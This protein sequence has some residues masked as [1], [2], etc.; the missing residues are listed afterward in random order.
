ML[1]IGTSVLEMALGKIKIC[2]TGTRMSGRWELIWRQNLVI[3]WGGGTCNGCLQIWIRSLNI[4]WRSVATLIAKTKSQ[5]EHLQLDVWI[6]KMLYTLAQIEF[7]RSTSIHSYASFI[8]LT[9]CIHSSP[10]NNKDELYFYALVLVFILLSTVE[11][12]HCHRLSIKPECP[13]WLPICQTVCNI[14]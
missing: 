1:N 5:D 7:E 11:I 8:T 6:N 12:Q 2:Y 14:K 4:C 10:P 3:W 9:Y 13:M